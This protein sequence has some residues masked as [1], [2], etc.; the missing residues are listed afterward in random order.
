MVSTVSV[1]D[2]SPLPRLLS[3]GCP[4]PWC[5]GA[6]ELLQASFMRAL[7]VS[8]RALLLRPTHL[9]KVSPPDD[10]PSRGRISKYEIGG[11]Q[12]FNLYN[13]QFCKF[14]V[15]AVSSSRSRTCYMK[16]YL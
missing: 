12:M 5:K 6:R 7:V 3:F 9:P 1:S 10:T 14:K 8:M 4:L 13:Y 15:V 2:E 16:R 11:T